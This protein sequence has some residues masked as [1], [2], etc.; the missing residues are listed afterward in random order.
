MNQ[1]CQEGLEKFIPKDRPIRGG[2]A[3][4]GDEVL[5]KNE[6]EVIGF[7]VGKEKR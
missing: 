7:C 6:K 2:L 1:G 4:H 3:G 5:L